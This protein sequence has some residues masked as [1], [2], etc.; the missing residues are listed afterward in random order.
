MTIDTRIVRFAKTAT[1]V[2]SSVSLDDDKTAEPDQNSDAIDVDVVKETRIEKDGRSEDMHEVWPRVW[3]GSA[4]AADDALT[5]AG[6]GITHVVSVLNTPCNTTSFPG[7]CY[8]R[9]ELA[10][11][12]TSDIQ[13]F[14]NRSYHFIHRALKRPLA[15]VL[16]HCYVGASR[17]T[18]LACSYLM[19]SERLTMRQALDTVK[20]ARIVTNPNV[21]F[22]QQLLDYEWILHFKHLDQSKN[23]TCCAILAAF[24]PHLRN[25]YKFIALSALCF[26]P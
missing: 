6:R 2:I 14:F 10:N 19:R 23:N 17:S 24:D 9:L 3:V 5:M 1:L 18:A 20:Q 13:Q 7:V 11:D 25:T 4:A 21:G 8:L 12:M 26:L 22:R 16:I 15:R